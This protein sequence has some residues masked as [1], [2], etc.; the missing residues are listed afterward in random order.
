MPNNV[1]FTDNSA[2]FIEAKD[3]AVERIL[4]EIG[5]HLEGEARIEIEN[6]PSRVDTGLLRNSITYAV[7]GHTPA[8]TEY[9]EDNGPGSGRYFGSVPAEDHGGAVYV[10]TNVEYAIYV[11]EGTRSMAPGRFILNAVRKNAGRIGKRE[12]QIPVCNGSC[13][14]SENFS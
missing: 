14:Q 6:A 9:H 13:C 5:L 12:A 11:H 2:T 1:T 3:D 7:D 10:G 8:I 4:A